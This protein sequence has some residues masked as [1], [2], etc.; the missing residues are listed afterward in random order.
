M[1]VRFERKTEK[2]RMERNEERQKERTQGRRGI[3]GV[4]ER[5]RNCEE[6]KW[7]KKSGDSWMERMTEERRMKGNTMHETEWGEW[8]DGGAQH[9]L[10][11]ES[12][13]GSW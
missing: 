5:M 8:Q 6:M 12:L 3:S 2:R 4:E 13:V 7:K 1:D 9:F 10:L 11:S